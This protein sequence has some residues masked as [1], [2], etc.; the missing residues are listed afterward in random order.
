MLLLL[1]SPMATIAVLGGVYTAFRVIGG[2]EFSI[3]LS[4]FI[5]V[6]NNLKP[7]FPYLTLIPAA[8]FLLPLLI[9]NKMK[10]I[11]FRK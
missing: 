1:L 3:A 4:S 5:A 10:G 9:K 11:H 6:I 2:S 8:L 7:Y